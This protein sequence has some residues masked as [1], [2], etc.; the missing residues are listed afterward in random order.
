MLLLLLLLACMNRAVV[1]LSAGVRSTELLERGEL[2]RDALSSLF[3]GSRTIQQH[4]DGRCSEEDEVL[5]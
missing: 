4:R 2:S 5:M 1:C 3:I